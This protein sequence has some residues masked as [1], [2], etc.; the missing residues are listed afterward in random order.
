MPCRSRGEGAVGAALEL[1]GQQ[2]TRRCEK[3]GAGCAVPGGAMVLV[4]FEVT[5]GQWH[6]L[7]QRGAAVTVTHTLNL[8]AGLLAPCRAAGQT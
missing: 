6:C 1:L 3:A 4:L 2:A 8:E 5:D 7:Q